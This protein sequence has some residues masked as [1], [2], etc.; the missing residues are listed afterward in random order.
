MKMENLH[1]EQARSY[2]YKKDNYCISIYGFDEGLF[3]LNSGLVVSEQTDK[4]IEDWAQENYDA[5]NVE[6]LNNDFS[7][8]IN[9]VWRP[10]LHYQKEMEQALSIN[11]QERMAAEQSLHLFIQ[12]LYDLFLYIEPSLS[13]LNVYSHRTREFLILACT[14]V[15]NSWQKYMRYTSLN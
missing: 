10:G 11:Q 1:E 14:E 12:K 5:D 15:E 8:V 6:T 4:T 13:G 7:E 9:R 2:A 3:M